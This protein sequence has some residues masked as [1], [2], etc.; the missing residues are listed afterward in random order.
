MEKL[1]YLGVRLTIYMKL[2]T[3]L[4]TLQTLK[5]LNLKIER[6]RMAIISQTTKVPYQQQFDF[7]M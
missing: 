5:I 3:V 4:L 7:G 1:L 2:G 6:W